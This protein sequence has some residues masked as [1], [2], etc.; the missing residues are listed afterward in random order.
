MMQRHDII[1]V[2]RS[3]RGNKDIDTVAKLSGM[4]L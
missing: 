4:T 2:N 3:G 1:P